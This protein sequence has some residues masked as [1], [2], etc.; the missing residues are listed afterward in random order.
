[1]RHPPRRHQYVGPAEILA[2]LKPGDGG[3]PIATAD[4]L[5]NWLC[6]VPVP[7]LAEPFTFVVDLDGVLRLAPRRSEHV[8]C[9]G[10]RDVLAAGEISFVPSRPDGGPGRWIVGEISNQS[11]GYCPDLDS[12]AAV[13]AALD[14]AGLAHP[15]GFTSNVVFRC[16]PDCRQRNVVRDGDFVCALC[17]ADL[18]VRWN[19][20]R[21]R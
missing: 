5:A 20:D 21:Q 13:A 11:T 7:D 17:G 19:F 2:S 10:G 4:H 15:D 6:S 9:A 1:M 18:P 8:A 12:W 14:R 16:C 3:T